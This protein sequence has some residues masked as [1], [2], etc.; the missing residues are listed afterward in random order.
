MSIIGIK[1]GILLRLYRDIVIYADNIIIKCGRNAKVRST[2]H[3]VIDA[4]TLIRKR[5]GLDRTK[6]NPSNHNN[7]YAGIY[8]GS[9]HDT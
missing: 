4:M 6:E 3:F 5:L 8:L 1:R 9:V 2:K 7:F